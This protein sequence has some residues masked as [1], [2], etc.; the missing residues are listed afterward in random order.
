[1]KFEKNQEVLIRKKERPI[2]DRDIPL[3]E[4]ISQNSFTGEILD[5]GENTISIL[6]V[7]KM[8]IYAKDVDEEIHI[9]T[10]NLDEY[11]VQPVR[12]APLYQTD[13]MAIT[14]C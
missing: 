13:P 10:I 7:R 5:I 14:M 12:V 8:S 2:G 11:D 1:M 9:M 3:N 4:W 6:T